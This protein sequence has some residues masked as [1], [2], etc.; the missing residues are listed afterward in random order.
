[1]A[2]N[3]RSFAAQLTLLYAVASAMQCGAIRGGR[4]H[5]PRGD[6]VKNNIGDQFCEQE[7]LVSCALRLVGKR[8]EVSSPSFLVS[9]QFFHQSDGRIRFVMCS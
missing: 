3:P 6:K 4:R 7:S 5:F 1:M 9:V 2:L 8:L